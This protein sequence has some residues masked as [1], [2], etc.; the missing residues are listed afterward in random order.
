MS[1]VLWA[2]GFC[3]GDG[4]PFLPAVAWRFAAVGV[5]AAVLGSRMAR[6]LS[7]RLRADAMRVGIG[8]LAVASAVGVG[9]RALNG[10]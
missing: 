3:S 1:W 5:P 2:C 6:R 8:V 7:H 10:F 4:C 9:L